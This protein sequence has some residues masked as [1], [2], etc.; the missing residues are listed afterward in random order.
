SLAS[1]GRII[2]L[3][4]FSPGR[5]LDLVGQEGVAHMFLVPAMINMCLQ[6]P[7]IEGANLSTLR[8][9][10]YGASPISEAVLAQATQR[11]GYGC[12]QFSGMADAAGGGTFLK[13]ADHVGELLRSC[14]KPWPQM[15]VKILRY[16]G[17]EADTGEIGEI[18]IWGQMVMAGYWNRE[19]A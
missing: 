18:A 1:G 17:S 15:D 12:S 14:G 4:E 13:P 16:D 3:P 7:E 8:T 5:V 6:A 11:L 10:A 19:E 9:V 2:V